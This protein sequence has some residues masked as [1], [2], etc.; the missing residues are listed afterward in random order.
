MEDQLDVICNGKTSL[1]KLCDDCRNELDVAI[2][3]ITNNKSMD[4]KEQPYQ[5]GIKIDEHHTWIIGKYGPIIICNI[6]EKTTFKKVKKNIDLD[7]LKRGE[8]SLKDIIYEGN[9]NDY[10]KSVGEIDN[11]EI[12]VKKG[13]FGLYCSY[14]GKNISL[15]YS[16]KTL[17]TITLDDVKK[18]ISSKKDTNANILKKLNDSVSI[19][20]GKWGPYVYYKTKA[21]KKPRFIPVKNI[22]W[23]EVDLD[24]VYDNL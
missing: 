23:K 19:R 18:V 1:K 10:S 2:S 12:I 20:Q 24:W 8:Y 22:T 5:K 17:E 16:K 6:N 7:K 13:K 9:N 15:K 3:S 21:M 4:I 11:E 14:K